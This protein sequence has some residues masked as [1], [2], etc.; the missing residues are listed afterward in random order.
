MILSN[1][2]EGFMKWISKTNFSL[3]VIAIGLL[4][5][6]CKKNATAA[7]AILTGPDAPATPGVVDNTGGF[8][9]KVN[10]PADA[11][12]Y[13]HLKGDFDKKCVVTSATAA[14]ADRNI[15]C[16]VEAEEL[17]AAFYGID[18][19]LNVPASMCKFATFHTSYYYGMRG[20]FGP[21]QVTINLDSDG[22]FVSGSATIS[23]ADSGDISFN[24]GQPVCEFNYSSIKGP[25]CC[26]GTYV[27]R[28]IQAGVATPVVSTE[29]WGGKVAS[30]LQGSGLDLVPRQTVS[31]W[32][33]GLIY[34]AVD[35]QSKSFKV[36]EKTV[37][38]TRDSFW[39]A[40]YYTSTVPMPFT[41]PAFPASVNASDYAPRP[42]FEW[43]C[44][45]DADEVIARIKVQ[46]REWNT[47]TEFDLGSTG[48]P[49]FTGTEPNWGTTYNDFFDW[50]DYVADGNTDYPGIIK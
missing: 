43:N 44:L 5:T 31:Q 36:G 28:V 37:E 18:M 12:Y 48:N 13:I 46:I 38:L 4:T 23:P 21:T 45:D 6:G 29:D 1:K 8:N 24:E 9:I 17:E 20:G 16:V 32:P 22:N 3:F 2:Q 34:N 26:E 11:N 7:D 49:D 35:G 19:V 33:M 15:E 25:N 50:D 39:F 10:P 14:F 30:C 40:N 27:K 47:T 41:T 42:Y